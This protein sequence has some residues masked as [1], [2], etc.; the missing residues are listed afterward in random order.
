[1]MATLGEEVQYITPLNGV[2]HLVHSS[3]G[4]GVFVCLTRE[5]INGYSVTFSCNK[6]LT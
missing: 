5:Q 2:I 1:M 4:E 3:E 6:E